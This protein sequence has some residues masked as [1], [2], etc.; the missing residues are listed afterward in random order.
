MSYVGATQA[1][2]R[3]PKSIYWRR[4]F[5][6][7]RILRRWRPDI[8]LATYLRSNGLLAAFVA[9]GALVLSS[10]GADQTWGLSPG[11]DRR[12][13]RW[14]GRRAS[15]FHASSPELA[16]GLVSAGIEFDRITVIPMGVDAALFSPRTGERPPGPLRIVCTRKHF[17][18]YDNN[19]LVLALARL[20]EQGV[21]FE[22]RFA[23]GGPMLDETRRLAERMGLAENVRFVEEIEHHEVPDFLRWADVFVSAAH[24]DGAPSSLFEAMSCGLF[25]I[26]TDA[27]ANRDWIVH[28]R[29]GYL[30]QAG[31]PEAWMAG[32]LFYTRN[33]DVCREAAVANRR[34]VQARCD[35]SA[36][37]H[38]MEQLLMRAS[39]NPGGPGAKDRS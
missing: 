6:V 17:P 39:Q 16:E 9:P 5:R 8:V 11:I 24:S 38:A 35:R 31:A 37:L 29:T 27:R 18:I 28:E 1:D 10:R 20:R 21:A 14:M 26:V 30:C 4:L 19:T 25:P 22:C 32:I 36:G 3:L 7:R 2:G 33:P 34:H 12:L 15:A 23:S 13:I